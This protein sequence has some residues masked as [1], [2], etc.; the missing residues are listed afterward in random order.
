MSIASGYGSPLTVSAV[1]NASPAACTSTAHGLTNGDF[2]EFTSG[3][4]KATNRVFRVSG[5]TTNAF[6]LEG[7]DTT[8]TSIFPAGAGAGS[9]RK[10]TGWTQL[11]QILTTASE[12]GTQNFATYQFL[13]AD[14]EVRI[15]TNKAA[16]G[17]NI[18]VADD[19]SLAGYILAS[20]ANDDRLQRAVKAVL[21]NASILLYSGYIS[22]VK[23]PSMNV[24]E[25][26][27]VQVT[28]SFL[29]A[30]PVRYAS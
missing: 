5:S 9:V 23:T 21:S 7:L 17:L 22:V 24:N 4:S 13:E 26:M 20:T 2:V 19:P 8:L 27:K 25:P 29:N 28:V 6:N 10:I 11:Q 15:P 12:G 3:W 14:N 18:E 30:E 1:T 16:A